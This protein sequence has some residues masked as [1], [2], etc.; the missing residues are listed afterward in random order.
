MMIYLYWL[1]GMIYHLSGLN[2]THLFTTFCITTANRNQ[3]EK[4]KSMVSWE[5]LKMNEGIG[6]LKERVY[7]IFKEGFEI[8]FLNPSL[9][10]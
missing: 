8:I 10:S 3:E 7:F 4:Q 9:I 1:S 5:K 6:N 2:Y